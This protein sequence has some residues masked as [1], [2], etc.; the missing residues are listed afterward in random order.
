MLT[1][2][3]NLTFLVLNDAML[4]AFAQAAGTLRQ[5]QLVSRF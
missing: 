3:P 1:F 2:S 5:T 4:D